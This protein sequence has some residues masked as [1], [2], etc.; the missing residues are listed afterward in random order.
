VLQHLYGN[1]GSTTGGFDANE[2]HANLGEDA[3]W[4][5]VVSNALTDLA[6]AGLIRRV[7]SA[8]LDR[9]QAGRYAL[10]EGVALS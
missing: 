9:E 7:A 3:P 5:R 8:R 4:A 1:S 2:V 6:E 10:A